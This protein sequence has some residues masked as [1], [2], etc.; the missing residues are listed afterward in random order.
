[1]DILCVG[2]GI[3]VAGDHH[4]SHLLL[5]FIFFEISFEGLGVTKYAV[6]TH[7]MR[8]FGETKKKNNLQNV[9]KC[10]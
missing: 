2:F 5:I 1:M 9:A 8:D 4:M 6:R 3:S 10:V 7:T